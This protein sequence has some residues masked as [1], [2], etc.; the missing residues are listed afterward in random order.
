MANNR[1]KGHDAERHYKKIFEEIFG[2]CKT[3]REASKLLDDCLVDLFGIPINV[4]IKCG[5]QRGLNP[6]LVLRDMRI[7]LKKHFPD[8][9]ELPKIII[10]KKDVGKG[11]KRDEYDELVTM[12]FEDFKTLL[13]KVYE[14]Q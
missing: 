14:K 5:K 3:S 6:T 9:E 4:Q 10:H 8:K 2:Y 11:R 13:E 12:S 7:A 1:R